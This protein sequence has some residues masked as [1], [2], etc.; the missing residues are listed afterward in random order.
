MHEVLWRQNAVQLAQYVV[1]FLK[2]VQTLVDFSTCSMN[3]ASER[4]I[5]SA[6]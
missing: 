5:P 4:G 3:S 2:A 1:M 6:G